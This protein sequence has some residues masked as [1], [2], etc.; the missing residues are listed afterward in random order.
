MWVVNEFSMFIMLVV[1]EVRDRSMVCV[2]GSG[3]DGLKVL[4][5]SEC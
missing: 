1:L 4:V 3:E 5:F 2:F